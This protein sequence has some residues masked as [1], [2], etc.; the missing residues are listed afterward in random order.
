MKKTLTL[1][2]LLASASNHGRSNTGWYIP[3]QDDGN[4][5]V[6]IVPTATP[7][8][9]VP[10]LNC[11]GLVTISSRSAAA[12]VLISSS[13]NFGVNNTLQDFEGLGLASKE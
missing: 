7:T 1:A 5:L 9:A 12:N 13:P 3:S 10:E 8:L 4:E 2:S 6:G 11:D